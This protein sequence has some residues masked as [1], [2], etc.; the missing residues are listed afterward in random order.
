M[1]TESIERVAVLGAGIMGTGIACHLANAGLEVVLLD[2]P[3]PDGK[4]SRNAFADGALKKAQ[5]AKPSPIYHKGLFGRIQTGNLE[6]DLGLLSEC[7]WVVEA[8]KEDLAIKQSLFTKVEEVVSESTIISSNTSGIPLAQLIE[9]RSESF[10]ERFMITHFFNPVRYMR[11]LELVSGPNTSQDVKDRMEA[12]AQDVLGKGV[13]WAKDTPNFVANRIGT[14]AMMRCLKEMETQGLSIEEV[15]AIFGRPLGRPKSAVFRTGDLVGLDL[16]MAVTEHCYEGLPN[17]PRRD[18]YKA[19][20]WVHDLV[21]AGNLGQKSGSGFYRK[22]K[23]SDDNPK[24]LEVWDYKT[25]AY[26]AIQKVRISSLGVAR[27]QD[28]LTDRLNTVIWAEDEAGKMAWPVLRDTLAYSAELVGEIADD[29]LSIDNGMKWGFGWDSGPFETWDALGFAKV[30][31]KMKAEGVELPTWVTEKLQAGDSSI[32]GEGGTGALIAQSDAKRTSLTTRKA[33]G[34]K[35]VMSNSGASVIDIGDDVCAL[36]FHTKANAI[37]ADIT[38]M[39]F[40][41]VDYAEANAK[42]LVIYNEG[43]QFSLGA[44]LMLIFMYAQQ[45]QW[46]QC[47]EASRT[48]QNAVQR[49][50]YAKVPVVAAPHGMALGGGCE[51]MLAAGS[52][53]GCRP[54]AELYTGLVEVGVGLIP[55][56][57]GTVNTLFGLLER[58]PEG[59]QVDITPFVG[60]AFEQIAMA[61]VST[62]AEEAR[63]LGYIPARAQITLDRSRQLHDAKAYALG[64]YNSG[65]RAPKPRAFRL[66][67]ESGIATLNTMVQ[68]LV[69]GGQATEHD[70]L[71]AG[72][73]AHVL[74]GGASGHVRKV[75]EQEMLDLEREAFVSLVGEQKSQDRI[76]HML[77][78]N[79]PLRN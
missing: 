24:G 63:G 76:S 41:A 38:A 52:G 40:E 25:G 19:S 73:V 69:Q 28:E 53:A 59:A 46:D 1:T 47:E 17:D 21:A 5:K 45:Q 11:L 61:K 27:N 72:K 42:G 57:G 55:G 75:T 66:L 48:L 6:D 7:Q 2:I 68:G 16:L 35:V 77:M 12:F 51:I 9:G 13:V 14:Y 70:A 78:K 49:I 10:V 44:N 60:K 50:R 56:A 64:L 15:D 54:H 26:R 32:Y 67:G 65:Y 8:V 58:I 22:T 23:K 33:Q 3:P 4:G 62:S 30:A 39:L 20:S 43:E 31:E 71:I 79:K 29:Q 18:M 34:A 37:D 36:E 74:C